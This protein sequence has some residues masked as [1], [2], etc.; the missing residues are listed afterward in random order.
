MKPKIFFKWPLLALCVVVIAAASVMLQSRPPQDG[1]LSED[2]QSDVAQAS[3]DT[4][5]RLK[6]PGINVDASV[7]GVGLTPE[8]EMDVPNNGDDVG[9]F[10]LGTKVGYRGSAVIAGHSR[11]ESGD[12]SVFSDLYKLQSGD[13]IYFEDKEGAITTFVVRESRNYDPSADASEVFSSDDGIAHLNLITCEGVWDPVAES[14][15]QRLV[16]F[17]DKE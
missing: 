6:I 16:V 11:W 17:T 15:S 1:S 13:K 8:G 7:V 2:V 12:R 3:V 4:S 5:L 14:Y 10:K 9:W